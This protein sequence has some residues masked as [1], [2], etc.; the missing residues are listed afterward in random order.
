M[1]ILHD[2][3]NDYDIDLDISAPWHIFFSLYIFC[4]ATALP[5]NFDY[6]DDSILVPP[7]TVAEIIS[8]DSLLGYSCHSDRNCGGLVSNAL[9]VNGKCECEPGYIA[10]GL[11]SCLEI[12]KSCDN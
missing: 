10:N 6:Y 3:N 1:S 9:C 5:A 7:T 11:W 8:Y 2:N 4:R 12:K